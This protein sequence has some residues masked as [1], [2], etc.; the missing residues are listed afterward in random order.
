MA[1]RLCRERYRPGVAAVIAGP[2]ARCDARLMVYPKR[3]EWHGGI[4][5]HVD[6]RPPRSQRDLVAASLLRV[7]PAGRMAWDERTRTEFRTS[8]R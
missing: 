6:R 8:A 2:A 4:S 3:I 5:G 1:R 7:A